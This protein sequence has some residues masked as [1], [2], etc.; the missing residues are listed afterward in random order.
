[1]KS[2]FLIL[3]RDD[4]YFCSSFVVDL[5][6]DSIS[7]LFYIRLSYVAIK[8]DF[9]KNGPLFALLWCLLLFAFI[10]LSFCP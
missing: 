5:S 10:S 9:C 4:R 8:D 7:P 6:S 3:G 2:V 1:M